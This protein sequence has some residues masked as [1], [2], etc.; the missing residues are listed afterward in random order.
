ML[1]N[2]NYVV[3]RKFSNI[4]PNTPKFN[5]TSKVCTCISIILYLIHWIRSFCMPN[6]IHFCLCS[7]ASTHTYTSSSP[8][9]T[10]PRRRTCKRS[11]AE[12]HYTRRWYQ[13]C[14]KSYF[15]RCSTSTCRWN[16]GGITDV[17][18]ERTS[19]CIHANLVSPRQ[20]QIVKP[21]RR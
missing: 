12:H 7:P 2:Q 8:L 13:H 15:T 16:L 18:G 4:P 17:G 20:H 6:Y 14:Q 9:S 5:D 1:S 3:K 21:D 11:A 19:S 10:S